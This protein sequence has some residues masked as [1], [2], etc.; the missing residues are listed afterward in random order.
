MYIYACLCHVNAMSICLLDAIT[1]CHTQ[2]RNFLSFHILFCHLLGV[3]RLS[4]GLAPL[5]GNLFG[6]GSVNIKQ[7]LTLILGSH[8]NC[9]FCIH[10]CQTLQRQRSHLYPPVERAPISLTALSYEWEELQVRNVWHKGEQEMQEGWELPLDWPVP[11]RRLTVQHCSRQSCKDSCLNMHQGSMCQQSLHGGSSSL[12]R[13]RILGEKGGIER[14]EK[15]IKAHHTSLSPAWREKK[16]IEGEPTTR[17]NGRKA[18]KWT[19][20]GQSDQKIKCQIKKGFNSYIE[21]FYIQYVCK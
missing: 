15:S 1:M 8:L 4:P 10:V 18:T 9:Y 17:K 13:P 11:G 12:T 5:N 19:P 20:S 14:E 7:C 6:E 3:I 16:G 2:N 21:L